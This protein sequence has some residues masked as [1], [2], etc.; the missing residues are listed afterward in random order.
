MIRLARRRY[1]P[2]LAGLVVVLFVLLLAHYVN[3]PDAAS[4]SLPAQSG[5]ALPN[6]FPHPPAS[7]SRASSAGATPA[8]RPGASLAAQLV[9]DLPQSTSLDAAGAPAR[10]V[11]MV[12][13]S[14]AAIVQMGYIVR[15]GD[16]DRYAKRNVQS[17]AIIHTV[18][19]GY[20]V[21][22]E[23]G[24][25]ASPYATYVTCTLMVDGRVQSS[26]TSKGPWA[27]TVCVG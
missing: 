2:V 5:P 14:D 17:P 8:A 19:H 21:V 7:P 16:P 12:V 27:V 6:G 18:A 25:Q 15:G 26:H 23:I 11:T 1:K 9:P 4:I 22:A 3:G 10:A 24:A 13:R 20:G